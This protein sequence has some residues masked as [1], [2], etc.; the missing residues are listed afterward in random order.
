MSI[1]SHLI[2][3]YHILSTLSHVLLRIDFLYIIFFASKFVLFLNEVSLSPKCRFCHILSH[4]ITCYHILSTLSHVLLR[5]DILYIVFFAFKFVLFLNVVS[6]H[7]NVDFVTCY[8][9]LSLLIYLIT[10]FAKDRYFVHSLFRVQICSFFERSLFHRNVD[11]VTSYHMLSHLIYLITCFAKDRFFVHN[12]FRFQI[13]LFFERV[14]YHWNVHFVT[15]YHMLSHVITSYLPYHMFSKDRFLYIVF[16]ASKF[17]L[18]F[19]RS[20]FHRNVVVSYHRN[21]DFVTCYH[22]LSLL[23]YLITCFAKDRFLYIVFFASK[24]V[25]FFERSLF[26]PKCRFCHILSH[27]IYLITCF[28]NDRFLYI[29]FFA[30][31]FVLFWT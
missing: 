23:I 4:V 18:F 15:S 3:C 6:Y 29:V 31:K 20:L 8:H 2:T 5:I 25:L 22:M 19:E 14:S 27:L 21:V 12:L 28:A 16:F 1:L 30:P 26:S 7:R 11:F 9:M 13:C 24:V 10:Y 17:V